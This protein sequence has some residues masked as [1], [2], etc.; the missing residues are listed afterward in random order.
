[1]LPGSSISVSHQEALG[2]CQKCTEEGMP[3]MLRGEIAK[4]AARRT[5]GNAANTQGRHKDFPIAVLGGKDHENGQ[6]TSLSAAG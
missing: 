5:N 3:S 2:A 4:A 1:M 6:V